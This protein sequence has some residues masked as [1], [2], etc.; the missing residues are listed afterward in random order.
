MYGRKYFLIL[1]STA[2]GAVNAFYR[3]LARRMRKIAKWNV[4]DPAAV[5]V[6]VARIFFHVTCV[7]AYTQHPLSPVHLA[8]LSLLIHAHQFPHWSCCILPLFFLIGSVSFYGSIWSDSESTPSYTSSSSSSFSSSILP[9]LC[10]PPHS[11]QASF[12]PPPH[13]RFTHP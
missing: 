2:T 1:G 3:R 9:P 11:L 10:S 6:S 8:G 13:K 4:S 12:P 5:Q 7:C